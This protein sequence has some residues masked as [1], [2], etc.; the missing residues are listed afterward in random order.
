MPVLLL[1]GSA[2]SSFFMASCSAI[3]NCSSSVRACTLST[4]RPGSAASASSLIRRLV[5]VTCCRSACGP[6]TSSVSEESPAIRPANATNCCATWSER[7]WARAGVSAVPEILMTLPSVTFAR[8]RSRSSARLTSVQRSE[9][10][11][12]STTV[13]LLAISAWVSSPRSSHC[14]GSSTDADAV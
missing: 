4:V 8:T 3:R 9:A 11:A 6:D 7:R 10:A 12:R 14:P 13:E 5:V 2:S 1:A